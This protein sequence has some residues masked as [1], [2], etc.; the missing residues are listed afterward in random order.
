MRYV[1]GIDCGASSSKA[2]IVR[3]DGK[4]IGWGKGAPVRHLY[5]DKGVTRLKEAL[6]AAIN[7]AHREAVASEGSFSLDAVC[8]GI[9]VATSQ[10]GSLEN[11]ISLRSVRE[12][13]ES[14]CVFVVEDSDVALA[15]ATGGSDGMLIYSGT[16]SV[17]LGISRT[18]K[19]VK[20]GGWG[21]LLGDEGSGY[22]IGL[23]AL[24]RICKVLDGRISS[25]GLKD[26]VMESLEVND[27]RSL[28]HLAYG[29][30]L[31]RTKIASLTEIVA[32]AAVNND[33]LAKEILSKAAHDLAQLCIDAIPLL[34]ELPAQ[35]YYSGG[36]FRTGSILLD[37]FREDIR[38]HFPHINI[39]P[40]KYPPVIGAALLAFRKINVTLTDSAFHRF[41]LEC[42]KM[43][44][45]TTV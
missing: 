25:S 10:P 2:A 38:K 22:S 27:A 8:L 5:T 29:K 39:R 17:A 36:V 43:K 15:G 19:R 42:S 24:Q 41:D 34:D 37:I 11:E 3:Q 45:E 20:C 16:G 13:V 6:S 31:D 9:A 26:V 14:P 35:V 1:L 44:E 23:A 32:K 40:A 33:E 7:G 30:G 21:Y 28:I 4:V 18:G 12:V